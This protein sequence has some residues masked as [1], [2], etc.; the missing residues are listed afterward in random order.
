MKLAIGLLVTTRVRA[1]K[2]VT[3]LINMG[4][5]LAAF[6]G[7]VHLPHTDVQ[8]PWAQDALERPCTRAALGE[9][10]TWLIVTDEIGSRALVGQTRRQRRGLI[11]AHALN[12]SIDSRTCSIT[13]GI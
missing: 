4:C 2:S 7:R 10:R 8:M 9:S 6:G 1:A 13:S 3:I 11:A 5:S 12:T